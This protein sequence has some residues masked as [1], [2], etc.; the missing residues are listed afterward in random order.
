[1]S[2]AERPFAGGQVEL[3]GFGSRLLAQVIDLFWLIPL[4]YLL[5]TLA[6]LV[7][8]GQMSAGGE[9]MANLIGALVVLLFWVERQGTPGKLVLGLR[10]VDAE[11]GGV[12]TIGRLVLRYVGYLVSALP[13]GLGYLWALWDKR[14][15]GWHDK[16]AG[17][18]VV[19]DPRG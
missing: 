3:A 12:P 10:I 16:M 14:R 17:T 2:E 5:G 1:M 19:K 7:N 13:L 15:Q 8:G 18:L 6:A 4:S 9:L 11:T